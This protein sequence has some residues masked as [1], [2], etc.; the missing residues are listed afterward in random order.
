MWWRWKERKNAGIS[1]VERDPRGTET[2]GTLEQACHD[3]MLALLD[4]RFGSLWE[5][6]KGAI[7]SEI[8][9]RLVVLA[10]GKVMGFRPTFD[11]PRGLCMDCILIDRFERL[12]YL[13]TSRG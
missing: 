11:V 6:G 5:P 9:V 8:E 2:R 1:L 4:K 7:A 13:S 12:A 10:W 3:S